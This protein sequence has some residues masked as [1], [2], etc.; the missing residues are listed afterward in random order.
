MRGAGLPFGSLIFLSMPR[1]HGELKV[2]KWPGTFYFISNTEEDKCKR[3]K[4]E[5]MKA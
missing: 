2:G 3:V 1:E 4:M 5:V